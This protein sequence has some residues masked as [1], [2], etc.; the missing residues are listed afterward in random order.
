MSSFFIHFYELARPK[1][2]RFPEN[3]FREGY[4]PVPEG[5]SQ[6]LFATR[7]SNAS[8]VEYAF[9]WFTRENRLEIQATTEFGA[10]YSLEKEHFTKSLRTPVALP[11]LDITESLDY[12]AHEPYAELRRVKRACGFGNTLPAQFWSQL[13]AELAATKTRVVAM[14]RINPYSPNTH[15]IAFV[16]EEPFSASNQLNIVRET[17]LDRAKAFA[18]LMN[19]WPFF[20]QFF[21][22]KEESTGRYMHI[23]FY[24]LYEMDLYPPDELVP[25]LARLFDRYAH[26]PFPSLREQFDGNFDARYEEYQDALGGGA[27][28]TRLWTI[29]DKPIVPW[30]TRVEFDQAVARVLGVEVSTEEFVKLYATIVK[31]MLITQSL[32]KD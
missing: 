3:Y 17:D 25:S 28:Q 30:P 19:S 23:R 26:T 20:S 8:R 7:A 18:V 14:N 11:T 16:S 13:Q 22:L 2:R 10:E 4:R 29:L 27:V 15:L 6:F 12:I 32:R 24:D 9:L 1:L 31:E 5:V 21:L